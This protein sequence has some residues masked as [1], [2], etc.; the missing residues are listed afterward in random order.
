MSYVC[1]HCLTRALSKDSKVHH[2]RALNVMAPHVDCEHCYNEALF[3]LDDEKARCDTHKQL[4][5]L[6]ETSSISV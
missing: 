6:Q 2:V 3:V 1:E 5:L 4:H